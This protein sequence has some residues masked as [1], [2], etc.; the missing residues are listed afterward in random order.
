MGS[1]QA[2]LSRDHQDYQPS[3][4]EQVMMAIYLLGLSSNGLATK[5]DILR[6]LRWDAGDFDV[7][8]RLDSILHHAVIFGYIN[9]R[10]PVPGEGREY[11]FVKPYSTYRFLL[12]TVDQSD[13]TLIPASI[14]KAEE[15]L[16]GYVTQRLFQC[17][18]LLRDTAIATTR[19]EREIYH[20][21]QVDRDGNVLWEDRD[22]L[23][24]ATE[25]RVTKHVIPAQ[26]SE[27][28]KSWHKLGIHHKE[29]ERSGGD[30][31]GLSREVFV[32]AVWLE[33]SE[34][35]EFMY[36]IDN[37]V[38]CD[39]TSLDERW[40]QGYSLSLWGDEIRYLVI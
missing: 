8:D 10:E 34:L 39:R 15:F 24:P 29:E 3:D 40:E 19:I 12:V 14:D 32:P 18:Y 2:L 37:R 22:R 26:S 28:Y 13:G 36:L 20:P 16:E 11:F 31:I 33:I 25:S 5:T 4:H 30:V 7:S 6:Y 1:I 21:V 9:S 27:V 23:I 38:D 17:P 35:K